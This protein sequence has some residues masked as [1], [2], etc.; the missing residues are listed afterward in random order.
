MGRSLLAATMPSRRFA[1]VN[2]VTLGGAAL[3]FNMQSSHAENERDHP[4]AN[5]FGTTRR[6]WPQASH[7]KIKSYWPNE[8][9]RIM[10]TM[11]LDPQRLPGSSHATF[12]LFS[13]RERRARR[14]TAYPA[15]SGAALPGASSHPLAPVP[16]VGCKDRTWHIDSSLQDLHDREGLG[17]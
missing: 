6:S 8:K 12:P 16:C 14:A 11:W 3:Y 4:F 2:C 1:T 15:S 13:V 9:D 7:F 17:S 10:R 5:D